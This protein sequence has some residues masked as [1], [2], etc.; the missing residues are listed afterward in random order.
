MASTGLGFSLGLLGFVWRLI[1]Y[2]S[3]LVFNPLYTDRLFHCYV[4]DKSVCN[5]RGVGS[6]LSLY[7]IFDG[8][9]Y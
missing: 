3:Y 1:C 9:F 4:L 2:L 8:K 6:I 7:F 5:F